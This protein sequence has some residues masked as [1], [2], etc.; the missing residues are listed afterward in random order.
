MDETRKPYTPPAVIEQFE[1]EIRAGSPVIGSVDSGWD[2]E[3]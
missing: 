3:P 2:I 1:L